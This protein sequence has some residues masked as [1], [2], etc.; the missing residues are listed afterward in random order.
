LAGEAIGWIPTPQFLVI[1]LALVATLATAFLGVPVALRLRARLQDAQR[2]TTLEDVADFE[3][4]TLLFGLAT[5]TFTILLVHLVLRGNLDRP[6]HLG[7]SAAV[8]VATY[9]AFAATWAV[10]V[11]RRHRSRADTAAHAAVSAVS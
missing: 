8:L 10:Q 4:R 3:A 9:L 11:V 6:A 1:H 7:P 5:M 2:G